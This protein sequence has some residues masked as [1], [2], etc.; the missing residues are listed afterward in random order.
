M[1]EA[2]IERTLDRGMANDLMGPTGQYGETPKRHHIDEEDGGIDDNN[3]GGV[4]G[5]MDSTAAAAASGNDG[6]TNAANCR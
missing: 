1:S 5:G 3:V 4:S 2:V 6:S